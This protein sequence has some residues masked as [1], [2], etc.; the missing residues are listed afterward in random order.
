LQA[1][2]KTNQLFEIE[3]FDLFIGNKPC[4]NKRRNHLFIL[5]QAGVL[6][7]NKAVLTENRVSFGTRTNSFIIKKQ[8]NFVLNKTLYY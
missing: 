1:E 7:R 8:T 4:F 2:S 3:Q 5:E 6:V